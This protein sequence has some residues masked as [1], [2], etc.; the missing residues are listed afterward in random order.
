MLDWQLRKNAGVSKLR[1]AAVLKKKRMRVFRNRDAGPRKRLAELKRR[2]AVALSKR[3]SG[4]RN[5][6]RYGVKLRKK[7]VLEP[8]KS[9][10]CV[11]RSKS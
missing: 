8:K 9:G 11:L 3:K 6:P 4:S 5:W 10:A 1:L 2:R 7:R